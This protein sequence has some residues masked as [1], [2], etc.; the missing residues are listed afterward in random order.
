[1]HLLEGARRLE[2]HHQ[3]QSLSGVTLSPG[4]ATNYAARG[5]APFERA[6]AE[7]L[8]KATDKVLYEVKRAGRNRTV[9]SALICLS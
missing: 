1:M 5:T 6:T 3:G 7:E 4:I 2:I 8:I 9:E